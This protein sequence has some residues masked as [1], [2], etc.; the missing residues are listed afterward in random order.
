[1][2][3]AVSHP[4]NWAHLGS[5]AH[6]VVVYRRF[7]ESDFG[8]IFEFEPVFEFERWDVKVCSVELSRLYPREE[9]MEEGSR[10]RYFRVCLCLFVWV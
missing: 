1:M 5:V 3:G 4:Q 6:F 7:M 9:G 10:K 2:G 8:P